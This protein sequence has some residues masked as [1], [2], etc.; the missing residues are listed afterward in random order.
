MLKL[1]FRKSFLK[2]QPSTGLS[3]PVS[4][5]LTAEEKSILNTI[6]RKL[7]FLV[8]YIQFS[9]SKKRKEQK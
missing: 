3:V 4:F 2:S 1:S 9:S 5:C 8:N 7:D 6:F